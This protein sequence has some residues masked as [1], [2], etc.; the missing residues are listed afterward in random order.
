MTNPRWT[1]SLKWAA[2]LCGVV[3]AALVWSVFDDYIAPLFFDSRI[4]RIHETGLPSATIERGGVY[5]RMRAD[6]FFL[7]LPKGARVKQPIKFSGGYDTVD[8]D[9]EVSFDKSNGTAPHGHEGLVSG[10]IGVGGYVKNEWVPGG[11][12]VVY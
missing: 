8:G 11:L 10:S 7:P 1:P 9:M 12:V 6:D 3:S 4:E 5:F 2:V